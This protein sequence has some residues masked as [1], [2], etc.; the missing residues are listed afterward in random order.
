MCASSGPVYDGFVHLYGSVYITVSQS[1]F[2]LPD[3]KKS[4]HFTIF[5][6][7]CLFMTISA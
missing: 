2:S 4:C 5:A 3:H 7:C 6:L 1:F